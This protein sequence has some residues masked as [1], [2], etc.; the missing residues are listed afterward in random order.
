VK[1]SSWALAEECIWASETAENSVT[2]A[3]Y[4]VVFVRCYLDNEI[5]DYEI[6]AACGT[7]GVEGKST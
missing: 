2:G 7:H 1:G 4:F 5:K 3:S 6:S